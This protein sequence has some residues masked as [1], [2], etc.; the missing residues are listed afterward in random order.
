MTVG[1]EEVRV[2]LHELTPC[3]YRG[4][5]K[6]ATESYSTLKFALWH[7]MLFSKGPNGWMLLEDDWDEPDIYNP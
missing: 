3:D 2:Q 5:G 1:R 6:S 7:D 4:E